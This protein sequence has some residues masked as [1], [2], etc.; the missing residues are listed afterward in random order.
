MLTASVAG[1]TVELWGA[2]RNRPDLQQVKSTLM[3][4]RGVTGVRATVR[5]MSRAQCELVNL[6]SPYISAN[7]KLD[8][9][10]SVRAR[11]PEAQYEEYDNLVL[12][13]GSPGRDGYVYVDYYALDGSVVHLIP[14]SALP[15]NR[16]RATRTQGSPSTSRS[17][18]TP[19]PRPSHCRWSKSVDSRLISMSSRRS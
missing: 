7:R 6:F 16:M 12:D 3:N 11:T 15:T 18:I 13:L 5:Q 8:Q 2:V 4:M 14:S 19:V 10:I 9:R 1:G 17:S